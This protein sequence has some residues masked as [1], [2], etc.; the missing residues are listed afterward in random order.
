MGRLETRVSKE[1]FFSDDTRPDAVAQNWRWLDHFLSEL[2]DN[3]PTPRKGTYTGNGLAQAVTIPDLGGVPFWGIIQDAAGGTPF[4]T[5]TPYA[6]G[7]ITAWS[8]QG[9][10]LLPTG[11]YNLPG[12]TYNWYF[13][14]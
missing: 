9:F 2:V 11:A 7:A 12:H 14:A 8:Q 6:T 5:L 13:L 4:I 3:L 1:F 10:T